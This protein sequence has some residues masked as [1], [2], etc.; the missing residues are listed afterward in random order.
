MKYN[1][2][3]LITGILS[4]ILALTFASAA[5][6]VA[7]STLTLN[8]NS[9][10]STTLTSLVLNNTDAVNSIN[11]IS[12]SASNLVSG[13]NTILSG[14]ITN[15]PA[16]FNLS[17]LSTATISGIQ[18]NIPANQLAGQ[19]TGSITI[20]RDTTTISTIP[21][22]LTINSSPSI[23]LA[24]QTQ[25]T[26]T[27][28]GTVLVTNNGNIALNGISLRTSSTSDFNVT[29]NNSNFNLNSGESTLVSLN[30][31]NA[32]LLSLG[33][34]DSLNILATNGTYNSTDLAITI[35]LSYC[36]DGEIG[37]DIKV[38]SVTD[39]SSGDPWAWAPLKDVSMT[40]SVENRNTDSRRVVVKVGLIEIRSD[41]SS[42]FITLTDDGDKE[43]SQEVRI[44][45]DDEKDYD[46]NFTLSGDIKQDYTYRLYVKAYEKSNEDEQCT[47]KVV[48]FEDGSSN[49]LYQEIDTNFDQDVVLGEFRYST[50]IACGQTE[51]VSFRVYNLASGDEQ[52]FRAAL[53]NKELGI[54]LLS[55]SFVLDEGESKIV[56]FD[57]T[58]PL[59]AQEK[60]YKFTAVAD[61]D[62]RETYNDYRSESDESYINI[63]ATGDCQGISSTTPSINASLTS[64]AEVGQEL[65]VQVTIN[66]NGNMTD[67]IISPTN[68]ESW[69]SL[70]K[71]TPS[72]LN[73]PASSSRQAIITFKP[74]KAGTQTFTIQ[75]VYNGKTTTQTVSVNVAEK[76]GIFAGMNPII[77]YLIAAIVVI[78]IIILIVL[79]AKASSKRS[80][81]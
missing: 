79:I 27:Q 19:Y 41:G 21:I 26:K 80:E 61:Y 51:T 23:S 18:L 42:R 78:F 35:P 62:Y 46:F 43:I 59:S 32:G 47:S 50:P 75:A 16:A 67:F 72:I 8:A 28:N 29:F 7:P 70:V 11:N 40:I 30:S 37:T 77:L 39:D 15:F 60:F 20:L 73:I 10:T 54:S 5:L 14:N 64:S 36:S 55:D 57:V 68:Y 34:D 1:K 71:V 52:Q 3:L 49:A 56:D 58:M 48:D 17:N 69:A 31:S 81:F 65:S 76:Q 24:L 74:T 2:S 63:K 44:P 6:T 25:L 33:D 66:N 22:T 13:A 45:G 38:N 53:F 4:L 9:G 12:F